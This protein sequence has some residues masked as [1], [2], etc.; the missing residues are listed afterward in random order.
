IYASNSVT[1][2]VGVRTRRVRKWNMAVNKSGENNSVTTTTT[3]FD[4]NNV[5]DSASNVVRN[6]YDGINSHDV[7]SVLLYS[8]L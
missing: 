5:V 1:K 8:I 6:F 4:D 2:A 7:D 3:H